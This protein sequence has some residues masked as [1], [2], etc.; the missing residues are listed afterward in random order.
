MAPLQI[1]QGVLHQA[2]EVIEIAAGLLV[3]V[4]RA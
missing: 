2:A 4:A 3:E 1:V